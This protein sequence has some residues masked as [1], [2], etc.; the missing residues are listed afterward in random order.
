MA[1]KTMEEIFNSSLMERMK[2]ISDRKLSDRVLKSTRLEKQIFD[3]LHSEH[4]QLQSLEQDGNAKLGS[5]K[6]LV[7]DTFQSFYSLKPIFEEEYNL[8]TTAKKLNKFILNDIMNST[9][10]PTMKSL[11]EGR[12]LPAMEA[13]AEFTENLLFRLDELLEA[14]SGLKDSLNVLEKLEHKRDELL[15]K[16]SDM[17]AEHPDTTDPKVQ[18]Q[19][20]SAANKADSKT[21]QAEMLS[22]MVD[23]NL[24]KNND[25]IK[26]ILNISMQKAQEKAEATRGA[27]LAW[28]DGSGEMKNTPINTD[29]LQ[30]VSQSPMLRN[31]AKYLG[32]FKEMLCEKRKN[33]YTYGRGEKYDVTFGGSITKA[34][35]SELSLIASTELIPLFLR[36]YQNK[37][38]KQYRRREAIREGGGD[39]IVCLDESD[40]TAGGNA[41]WG[42]AVALVLMEICRINHR[43]FALIHFSGQT[44]TDLFTSGE[45]DR[46]RVL[47]SAETFL[48]G[49]TNFEAPLYQALEMIEN[50]II[51]KPDI[52]F[53]TDGACSISEKFKE[54]FAESKARYKISVTGILLDQGS[55]FEFSLRKFC[56]ELYRTSEMTSSAIAGRIMD[57]RI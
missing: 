14:A 48:G 35:T 17:M 56:D 41:A 26:D 12:E 40:S 19:I 9:E 5:F 6:S 27:L 42:K 16:L 13:T 8:T 57:K 49:G 52:V 28:G 36:K 47:V 33:S 51:Q 53:I 4:E 39:I 15:Q 10:Y 7:H 2:A 54:Q 45:Y 31:I 38:L 1:L 25:K 18:Q 30:K 22:T 11:C 32:R 46:D 43:S 37:K 50:G 3:E 29:I 20:I 21:Q 24:Q 34:L 55:H 44:K 23:R